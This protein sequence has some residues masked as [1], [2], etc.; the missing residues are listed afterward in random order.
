[1]T[2]RGESPA[3]DVLFGRAGCR[4]WVSAGTGEHHPARPRTTTYAEGRAT[5][6]FPDPWACRESDTAERIQVFAAAFAVRPRGGLRQ[7]AWLVE[8]REVSVPSASECWC[9]TRYATAAR[10]MLGAGWG[11]PGDAPAGH[12]WPD[13]GAALNA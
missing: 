7:N 3:T 9:G 2:T 10:N 13:R 6:R 5:V 8:Y 4:S 1:V 11:P 12:T